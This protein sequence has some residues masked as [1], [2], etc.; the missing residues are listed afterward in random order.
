MSFGS[1]RALSTAIA[2]MC[3]QQGPYANICTTFLSQRFGSSTC[4][5]AVLGIRFHR[6]E[7]IADHERPPGTLQ[8]YRHSKG[9]QIG[10]IYVLQLALLTSLSLLSCEQYVHAR[11]RV[12]NA[13]LKL[14]K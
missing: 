6:H 5:R 1:R 11:I 3:D 12:Y 7:I 4:T 10:A 13:R 14:Q 2:R 9:V 8:H